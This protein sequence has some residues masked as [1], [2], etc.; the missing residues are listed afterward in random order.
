MPK[1]SSNRQQW[2]CTPVAKQVNKQTDGHREKLNA[3]GGVC[4]KGW[5]GRHA[6]RWARGELGTALTFAIMSFRR[7]SGAP[8]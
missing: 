3:G 1:C 4:G 7:T 6:D 5:M 2:I 8:P